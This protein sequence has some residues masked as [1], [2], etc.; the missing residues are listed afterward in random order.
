MKGVAADQT[1]ET[2]MKRDTDGL[3]VCELLPVCGWFP[4]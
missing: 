4:V 2:I 1:K 3:P